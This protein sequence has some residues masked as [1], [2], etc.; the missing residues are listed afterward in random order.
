MRRKKRYPKYKNFYQSNKR[1]SEYSFKGR[2]FF[3]YFCFFAAVLILLGRLYALQ[4]RD[5]SEFSAQA[6]SLHETTA[7]LTPQRGLIY[8]QDKNKEYIPLAIN[9]KYF[10]LYVVPKEIEN[11]EKISE[12]LAQII[13][14]SYD[15]IFE[16]ASKPNDPYEL[17]LKKIEEDTLINKIKEQN[18]EGVYFQEEYYRYYPFDSLAAQTIGFV[19]ESD[20]GLLKG[21][22]GLEAYYDAILTGQKG[23]FQG[24]KDALGRLVRSNSSQEK[25][26]VEG[27]SIITTIDKNVQFTAEQSLKDLMITRNASKGT[28]IV[29]EVKTGKILAL[30]NWPTFNLNNFSEIT[31]YSLFR[32]YATEERYEPGSVIKPFTMFAGIDS[33]KVTPETTYVDKGYYEVGGYR[34]ENYRGDV[35]GKSTMR[36]VLEFSINTGAIFVAQQ[37][38]NETLRDYFTKFGLGEIT[39][40]D[41]PYEIAGD[42]S[43][44][45]Y[46]KINPTYFATASYGLGVSVTPMALIR[47]YAILANKGKM[48]TPY[49]VEST[50][51]SVS[52]QTSLIFPEPIENLPQIVNQKSAETLTSMLVGVIENGFG[53][54]AKIKGYSLAGKTGT[55]FIPLKEGGGY[56]EEEIHT[57]VGFFPASDPEYII[58]VK[59][60]R[61]QWGEGAASQTVTLAFKEVERFLINYYNIPPD[62]V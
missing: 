36:K 56:S 54:N 60:D 41:L 61:P 5:Y 14:L 33:G 43:N 15:E 31:D 19:A 26:Q 51:D 59:M 55:S 37:V 2:V 3:I 34:L 57:F 32:N 1:T 47:A 20:D 10:S 52:S 42:L 62:E 8:C 48:V 49:L 38:G 16:K 22:Y 30:A 11:P 40:I 45:E 44:L 39:G 27:V 18:L 53:G 25:K 17:L 35:Y 6:E 21:R 7:I 12:A 46:P 13:P 24:I 58:L 4:I 28:I 9:K 29:M 50:K 23:V